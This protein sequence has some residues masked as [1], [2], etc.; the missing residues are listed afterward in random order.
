MKGLNKLLVFMIFLS[1]FALSGCSIV[2]VKNSKTDSWQRIEKTK[3][4]VIGI[5]DSFVPM[6]FRQKDG[7]LVGYD[8]DL[9]KAVFKQYGIKPDFQT[10][11]WTMNVT[12]LRNQTIDLIWNGFTIT[13]ERAKVVRFS[14]PYL[15]ND[16]VLVTK[17]DKNIKNVADMDDET[18]GAQSGSSGV[19]DLDQRPKILKDRIKNKQPILYDSFNN[20]FIDLNA[21]RIQ[22]LLIDSIYAKYYIAHQADPKAYRVVSSGMPSEQFAVGMRKQDKEVQLKINQGLNR[23]RKNGELKKINHKW[24]GKDSQ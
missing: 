17:T 23:L 18:L 21:N 5:D 16:Q 3:K 24:F 2:R 22:G 10:I 1:A 9:A 14:E 20:A 13:P 7:K 15:R 6:D 4:V 12:E 11:D 8:V 19:Q